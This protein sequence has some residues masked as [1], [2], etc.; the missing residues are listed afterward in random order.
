[1]AINPAA[2]G[3]SA[4]TRRGGGRRRR[5]RIGIGGTT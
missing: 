3:H 4:V 2:N 1:M 5:S